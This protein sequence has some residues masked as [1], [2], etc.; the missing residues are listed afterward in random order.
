MPL[1][2]SLLMLPLLLSGLKEV[3]RLFAVEATEEEGGGGKRGEDEKKGEASL[4]V[5]LLLLLC[6]ICR[7]NARC[8]R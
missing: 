2:V 3:R 4:D 5:P 1:L 7:F 6:T 8:R